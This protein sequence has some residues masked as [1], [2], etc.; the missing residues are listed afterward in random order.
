MDVTTP[1]GTPLRAALDLQGPRPGGWT[2]PVWTLTWR[3]GSNADPG[4]PTA[5]MLSRFAAMRIR[6]ASRD[7]PRAEDGTLPEA[8]FARRV[9]RR[10]LSP[11]LL[12]LHPASRTCP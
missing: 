1:A 12:D 2:R 3:R 5:A 10:S 11:P 9:A 4:N 6:A 7:I 8:W